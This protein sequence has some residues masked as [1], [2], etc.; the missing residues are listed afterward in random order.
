MLVRTSG[1]S[2]IMVKETMSKRQSSPE[3]G[4]SSTHSL[5]IF[6]VTSLIQK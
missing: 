5:L 6:E 3:P 2:E 4:L 1:N